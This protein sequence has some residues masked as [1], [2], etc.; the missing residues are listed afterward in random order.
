MCWR[1]TIETTLYDPYN[2][3]IETRATLANPESWLLDAFC[4]GPASTAG[5]RVNSN[6]AMT[7]ATFYACVRNISEDLTK[8]PKHV[9]QRQSRGSRNLPDH[10]VQYVLD[11]PNEQTDR[12]SF[13]GTILAHAVAGL[14]GYAE[15][16]FD[17]AGHP[18]EL[19][20]L[21]PY[22]VSTA[23]ASDGAVYYK[24]RGV[25]QDAIIP[26]RYM[27]HI[28]GLGY[29]GITGYDISYIGRQ[30]LGAAIALQKYQGSFFGN[31]MNPQGI[32]KHPKVLSKEA[33]D[34]LREQFEKR[35]GGGD[36]AH[37]TMLLEEGLE[38]SAVSINPEQ[39]Q[40]LEMTNMSGENICRMFRMPQHKVGFL[41]HATFSNIEEQNIEY[42]TD[43][44]DA[45]RDRI[46]CEINRKL[47]TEPE[48][49]SGV[50][51]DISL[52]GM[53]R[54]NMAARTQYYKERYYMG[55]LNANEIREYEDENPIEDAN[56]DRYFVQQNLVPL[57]RVDDIFD[58]PEPAPTEPAQQ[59]S[60]DP[61]HTEETD[62][63]RDRIIESYRLILE[64]RIQN[65]ILR[66]EAD[67]V[68][69]DKAGDHFYESHERYVS[70]QL[71]PSVDAIALGLNLSINTADIA[72]MYAHLHVGVSMTNIASNN[73]GGWEDGTR[74][75]VAA[76]TII[77]AIL[78]AAEVT[79]DGK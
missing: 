78:K 54:G 39:A 17:G 28:H 53:L 38:W 36:N 2:R 29:D 63:T 7:I 52:K 69:R 66:I 76:Q 19:H 65:N 46:V 74:A 3:P 13:W 31:G 73:T 45:W 30:V 56:G 62:N 22:S 43:P 48:R 55:S 60:Q 75:T 32:L 71:K 51:V 33:G 58:T 18:M 23:R 79:D 20:L 42:V 8:L 21:D 61:P 4:G 1:G 70:D 27:L 41:N 34:R 35:Y 37:K 6:T 57:D 9:R 10:P 59:E 24:V 5:E 11:Y 25:T 40:M 14:D 72:A 26:A 16:V 77:A 49:R 47:F 44:I 68:R 64:N 50:Y 12:H 67:K 15:I